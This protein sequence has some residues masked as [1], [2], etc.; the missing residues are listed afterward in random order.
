MS[1]SRLR[2]KRAIGKGRNTAPGMDN[3]YYEMF[4][5]LSDLVPEEL[6]SPMNEIWKQGKLPKTW[7]PGKYPSSPSSYRPI[8]LTSVVCKR[9]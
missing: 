5:H 2:N 9:E 1:S 7:K 3:L 8:A 4:N 6:L